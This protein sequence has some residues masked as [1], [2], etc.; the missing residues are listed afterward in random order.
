[1]SADTLA[2]LVWPVD[3][4]AE[5]LEAL[6]R[7]AGVMTGTPPP[8]GAS[9]GID[10]LATA[11]TDGFDRA[12]SSY[13]ARAG[14]EAEAVSTPYGE[15]ERFVET[16]GPCIIRFPGETGGLLAIVAPGSRNV[17][18]L[19]ADRS[20]RRI[21][22]QVVARALAEP[23]E[24]PV[25]GDVER[26]L[27]D[28]HVV[29]AR[30]ERARRALL[31]EL[32][33]AHPVGGAWMIRLAPAANLRLKMAEAGVPRLVG[34]LVGAYVAEYALFIASWAILGQGALGG[35]I[36]R[37]WL[38]AWMLLLLTLVPFHLA[39]TWLQSRIAVEVGGVLKQRLL[40]GALKLAPE[41][42]RTEG[43]GQL[44]GRV[45]ESEAIESLLLSGGF[46]AL[47]AVV[48]VAVAAVV[49]GASGGAAGV[50]TAAGAAAAAVVA[51]A[52]GWWRAAVLVVFAG[53]VAVFGFRYYFFRK[54]WTESR[55]G[56][57]HE[58]LEQ[59][60]GHRTRLAQEPLAR[61]H[62]SEDDALERYLE[63]SRAM[64]RTAGLLRLVPRAW[65]AVGA[66]S[67]VSAL[68][69]RSV[70]TVEM[71]VAVGATLLAYQGLHKLSIALADIAGA[72]IGWRQM[73]P[74]FEAASSAE[75]HGLPS[76]WSNAAP[77]KGAAPSTLIDATDLVFRY[78]GRAEPALSGA[79]LRI[80][81]GDRLLLEGASG[82]GKS[83]LVSLL[84]GLRRPA[85]GL[86]LVGG[87]DW[88]TLGADGWRRH[89]V[90]APQFHDNH[91]LTETLSFNLLMG[92]RWPPQQRDL[93]EAAEL[94][95]ALG[96]GPLL[97]RMPA[98]LLQM[99]GEGGWQLSHGEKSRVYLARALLQGAELL[100][101]DESF[102][103]LDPESMRRCLE[104]V[105]ERAPALLVV[106]HP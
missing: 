54:A 4:L 12:L 41:S 49:L 88:Q 53:L 76:L 7:R 63:Q 55:L 93:A 90:A 94:C 71:A 84:S 45:V 38:I 26:S 56:M 29:P 99:V 42:V 91:I 19:A 13:A 5:L 43:A 37:G 35:R 34:S 83:T 98:G 23:V 32:L 96:L 27:A 100:L 11:D 75:V 68:A 58:L 64:D 59:M 57:T 31:R 77:A 92:R 79:G 25:A 44:F 24:L 9:D 65:L 105:I 70:D 16:A 101:L 39:G 33:R 67:I 106:A 89:V 74:L 51:P 69:Y 10:R 20:V 36:D 87:L 80:R 78:P 2:T 28:A 48:E 104:C 18:A 66:A 73:A 62:Q 22:V 102:G 47:F 8:L 3:R 85:T 21:S 95:R 86:L 97:E 30:R 72:V 50:T 81:S 1:L 40:Y 15:L 61:R 103:A 82:G 60:V 52:G 14:L 6:A 46:F 17:R